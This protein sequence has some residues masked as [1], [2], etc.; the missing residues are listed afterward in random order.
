MKTAMQEL[1]ELIESRQFQCSNEFQCGYQL[2]LNDILGEIKKLNIL[3]NISCGNYPIE[4]N[5][6]TYIQNK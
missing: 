5:N 6:Q 2:A 4:L 1:I 3:N